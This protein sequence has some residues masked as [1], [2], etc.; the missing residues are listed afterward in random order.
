MYYSSLIHKNIRYLVDFLYWIIHLSLCCGIFN[1][2]SVICSEFTLFFVVFQLLVL[3]CRCVCEPTDACDRRQRRTA[4]TAG[5]GRPKGL[6]PSPDEVGN[7][8]IES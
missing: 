4:L 6:C 5:F 2:S 1:V 8:S 7:F 3:L